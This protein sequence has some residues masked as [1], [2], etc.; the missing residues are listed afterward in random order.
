[1]HMTSLNSDNKAAVYSH[2]RGGGHGQVA[3]VVQVHTGGKADTCGG[4]PGQVDGVEQ[5][6]TGRSGVY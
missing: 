1:M 6:H 3:G 2:C 5:V 4:G